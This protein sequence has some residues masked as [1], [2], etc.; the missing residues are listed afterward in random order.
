MEAI[1]LV[2]SAPAQ[3]VLHAVAVDDAMVVENSVLVLIVL[4]ALL[5]V[6][7]TIL[8]CTATFWADRPNCG[9]ILAK[10]FEG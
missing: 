2:D 6:A 8:Y 3:I 7:D 4:V 10:F 9:C 5:A 1:P